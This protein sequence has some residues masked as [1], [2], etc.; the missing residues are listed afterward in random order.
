MSKKGV[1]YFDKT[2]A[3]YITETDEGY[4][5]IYDNTYLDTSS[6]LPVSLT[7][8]LSAKT[9]RSKTL[10]PFFDGLIPEGWLLDIARHHW[11]VKGNDRFE[12]L[13]LTCRDAIGA[14]SIVPENKSE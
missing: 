12:L 4:E 1:V 14:V 13:L 7:L 2:V 11:K 9:Y 6:S 5:F 10:F 3:G 8:P